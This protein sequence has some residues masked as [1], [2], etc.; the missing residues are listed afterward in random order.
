MRFRPEHCVVTCEHA[1]NRVPKGYGRLGLPARRL[2]E[3]IAWDPGAAIMAKRL[4]AELDCPLHLGRWTR[5]LVDLNRSL[6]HKK[7]MAEESFGIAVPGNAALSAAEVAQ[8]IRTYYR[9]YRAATTASIATT[10]RETGRCLHLSIHS[11]TPVVGGVVRDCDVGLLYDP[12]RPHELAFARALRPHLAAQGLRVRMNY[13]YRGTDDGF[14]TRIR[15]TLPAAWYAGLEIETNQKFLKT[16]AGA[17]KLGRILATAVA[18]VLA[19]ATC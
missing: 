10:L 13:P 19:A 7:L 18:N 17:D 12:R 8:R 11:F 2:R 6:G 3:H 15:T 16:P 5:L 1:S 14:T 9:P 4:A